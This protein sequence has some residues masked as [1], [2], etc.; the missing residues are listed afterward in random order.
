[1]AGATARSDARAGSARLCGAKTRS[2][3]HFRR[4]TFLDTPYTASS[5]VGALLNDGRAGLAGG[6]MR[7]TTADFAWRSRC[8]R[9]DHRKQGLRHTGQP[10]VGLGRRIHG[11]APRRAP[12][13]HRR[14]VGHGHR[15]HDQRHGEHRQCLAGD[16]AGGDCRC[17]GQRHQPRGVRGRP[18]CHRRG[19]PSIQSRGRAY[20]A[21][22]FGH[23]YR[24]N[25][26][27][28]PGGWR[29]PPHR[30]PVPR[31][32]LRDL[33]LLSGKRYPAGR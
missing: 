17:R 27:L 14:G 11:I 32:K 16:E 4:T 30:A 6:G 22:D 28:E 18:R 5:P 21:A 20:P 15:R 9:A 24:E 1:M 2:H 3:A 25:H 23:L 29:E 26:Q 10:G 7:P 33:R 12:L 13:C 19:R 31:V 8:R